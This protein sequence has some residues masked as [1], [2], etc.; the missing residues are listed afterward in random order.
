MNTTEIESALVNIE[1]PYPS[2][3]QRIEL[4]EKTCEARICHAL[5]IAKGPARGKPTIL[6]IGGVHAR[7]W[8]GPDTLVN[9]AADLMRAY[10]N[11][12]GLR[13]LK[14][15]FSAVDIR[16][17]IEKRSLVVFP[18][19]N[20]DGVEFSH[21]KQHLWRKNRNPT[22][23]K[24]NP[25]K[26]G[27][28]INRNYDFLWDFK[29]YFHPAAWDSS[30]ASDDPIEETFHGPAPF[31]EPETRNVRWL[32][33]TFKPAIF[34]DLHSY[35]GDVLYSWGNDEDQTTDPDQNF[36]N[37]AYDGQRGRIGDT[38]REYI[39]LPDYEIATGIARAVS[40]AMRDVRNRLY[41]PLQG[42]G[43]YPTCGTSDDYAA[44]RHIVSPKIPKTFAFTIEFNFEGNT[45]DPFLATAN[46]KT[47][48]QTMR[49]VIPGLIAL[50]L[51]APQASHAGNTRSERV[52]GKT[53]NSL[54]HASAMGSVSCERASKRQR[55]SVSRSVWT[56]CRVT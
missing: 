7:E 8:G 48:T 16:T 18:C 46:P 20:P 35:D 10:S 13:Y 43:L 1:A 51:V 5:H 30:L 9:F 12:K 38:Y 39:S 42:V 40:D 14:K 28:D 21:T 19:V 49:D 17:I 56:N 31:S 47:L 24:G 44:S 50:C 6:I 33:D 41:K 4:P 55:S 25:K 11:R 45:R 53:A 23:S 2:M 3:C 26:I 36:A 34:L 37:P 15:T 52:L 29:K 32:M 27:V 54:A 22:Y